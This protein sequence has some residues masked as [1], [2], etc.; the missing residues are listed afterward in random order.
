MILG[1]RASLPAPSFEPVVLFP[2]A[3][4]AGKHACVFRKAQLVT[5]TTR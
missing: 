1:A 2:T 4:P 3:P 5:I